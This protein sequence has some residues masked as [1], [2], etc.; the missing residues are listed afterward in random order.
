MDKA[1]VP[2]IL[3]MSTVV[4]M[5]PDLLTVPIPAL[6]VVLILKMLEFSAEMNVRKLL[7]CTHTCVVLTG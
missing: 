6:V 3:I 7:T 2:F 5:N 1:L 4:E